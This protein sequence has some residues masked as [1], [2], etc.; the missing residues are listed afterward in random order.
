MLLHRAAGRASHTALLGA[1]SL[2]RPRF[3]FGEAALAAAA[4]A[5]AGAVVPVPLR[6]GVARLLLADAAV[7]KVGCCYPSAIC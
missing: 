3:V 4:G 5:L 6:P 7:A 2:P 1:S